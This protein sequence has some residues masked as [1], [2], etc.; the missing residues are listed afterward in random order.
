M[1]ALLVAG[2]MWP[3]AA[4]P[5]AGAIRAARATLS[6]LWLAPDAPVAASALSHAVADLAAGKPE[7]ALPRLVR[8]AASDGVGGYALLYLGRA[9][10]ELHRTAEARATADRLLATGPRGHLADAARLLTADAAEADEDWAAARDALG[11]LLAASPLD[12]ALVHLRLG[13]ASLG[14]NDTAA[15][16]ESLRTV[17]FDHAL[18]PHAA[19]AAVE[20]GRLNVSLVP[21]TPEEFARQLKRAQQ[22]FEVRRYA[23]ARTAFA[24]LQR[25]VSPADKR[26]I[27][28]RLAACDFHLR[29]YASARNAL[30]PLAARE[31]EAEYFYFSTLRELRQHGEY[32]RRARAFVDRHAGHPLAER[33]LDELGTHYILVDQDARAAE[34]FAEQFSRN[35]RGVHADR[36]AWKAGWWMYRSGKYAD[37]VR[38]F[39]AAAESLPRN[40]Y[41]PAWLYWSARAH[42]R[43]GQMDRAGA[44]FGRVMA[45]YR[46]SYYG[47]LAARAAASLRAGA[48]P[49]AGGAAPA[50]APGEPPPNA[51]VIRA[52]LAASLYDDAILELRKVQNERGRSPLLDATL[53]YALNRKGD[54][55][56]GI[57]QMR[58]AYP[59]YIAAGGEQLPAEILQVIFPVAYWDLISR[60]AAAHELDPYLM[61]ALVAQE[62]T[63]QPAVRSPAGAW[64]LMQILPSTGR[65]VAQRLGIR[66][67]TTARLTQPEINV[68]I[69]MATFADRLKRYGSVAPALAS[70][71]AGDSRVVR[72][73]AERPGLDQ[74][75]FIDDIPFPET[76]H[77]VKRIL[78][79]AEDYRALYA[80][81][82]TS[83][84]RP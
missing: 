11:P 16:I 61:A 49:M 69:G 39:E 64:G 57:I 38:L 58:R 13:L 81:A 68:R 62:S 42:Q 67:F 43:L 55:R 12:P 56:A 82:S 52:L 36:A 45:E 78:G 66:P 65:Q 4:P 47:R 44:A 31:P 32:V 53:A 34:V 71:N 74:D 17:Y 80:D 75:E 33:T 76:Q 35:P 25:L 7:Q 60:Y 29:R 6:N 19:R 20:L 51:E 1:A 79:T 46:N 23:D 59:E 9:Q 40:D 28:L 50:L 8:A 30:G 10:L 48:A 5:P 54:L 73:L 70:Y 63:F 27:D 2:L 18:S 77:Y 83:R 15:G 41:R 37:A 21:G 26:L 22:L 14:A 3:G 72:W 84:V 24:V